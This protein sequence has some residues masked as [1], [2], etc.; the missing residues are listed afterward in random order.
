ML[1]ESTRGVLL[2]VEY[3]PCMIP[4]GCT[5]ILQNFIANLGPFSSTTP[6]SPVVNFA[7]V[8]FLFG[9]LRRACLVL[10]KRDGG[11]M[12]GHNRSP[13][14][15][16]IPRN[17]PPSST[18]A[19]SKGSNTSSKHEAHTY[20]Q[21]ETNSRVVARFYF[22]FCFSLDTLT[23][24]LAYLFAFFALSGFPMTLGAF[25]LPLLVAL[26][27]IVLPLALRNDRRS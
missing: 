9:F 11:W 6:L 16:C 27:V 20:C 15:R 26:A 21:H 23:I 17:T 25:A 3:R 10:I 19:S 18:C 5:Q 7:G 1:G 12:C 14:H 24:T 8:R 2:E 4:N 22:F 13:S